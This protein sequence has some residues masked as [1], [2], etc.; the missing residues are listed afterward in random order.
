MALRGGNFVPI[1]IFLIVSTCFLYLVAAGLFSR[2]VGFFE[3]HKVRQDRFY[4]NAHGVSNPLISGTKSL[5]ERRLKWAQALDPMTI[6]RVYG[7]SM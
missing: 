1:Q 5:A 6:D 2:S 3:Q 7:M 4:V